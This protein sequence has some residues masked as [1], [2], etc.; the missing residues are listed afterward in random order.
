VTILL[1]D[2]NIQGHIE[3]LFKRMRREPWIGFCDFLDLRL[4]SFAD[5]GLKRTDSDSVIWHWC[6]QQRAFLLTN[7]RND[8]G[9]ESLE[10][11]ICQFN[12]PESVPVFTIG[13]TE[14]LR[15]DR[16]YSDRV[17]WA[18]LEFLLRIDH[19]LGTGRLFLPGND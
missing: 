8:D 14:R 17:I 7:N 15:N 18:L 5:A 1:A 9:P 2:A 13:D 16:D 10:S 3:V 19:L 4:L 6:Q 11:T 12:T